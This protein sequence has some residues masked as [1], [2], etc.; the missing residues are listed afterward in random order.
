MSNDLTFYNYAK[1]YETCIPIIQRDYVQ[2]R[3]GDKEQYVLKRFLEAIRQSLDKKERLEL[4]FIYGVVD[5]ET[6]FPIDG[7]QRLTTLYLLHWF[8]AF[9]S[10]CFPAFHREIKIFTYKTR[11]SSIDFFD[12]IRNFDNIRDLDT[13]NQD[14]FEYEMRSAPWFKANWNNDPTVNAVIEALCKMISVFKDADFSKWQ[15]LLIGDDCPIVFQRVD[16]NETDALET[17]FENECHAASTYIKMNARGKSLTDFENAKALI[18]SL[19]EDGENFVKNYN[20]E[21]IK[22]IEEIADQGKN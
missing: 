6:F 19:N 2:G 3:K 5:K 7:Q 8:T 1:K 16:I 9:K 17:E 15:N 10:G 20:K 18:H 14:K 11:S 22:K 21:Y 12:A 13:G 4:N